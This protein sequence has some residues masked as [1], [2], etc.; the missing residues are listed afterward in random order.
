MRRSWPPSFYAIISEPL[1]GRER[2]A[3]LMVERRVPWIQLR[4]KHRPRAE[5][6]QAAKLL[7]EIIRPPSRFI[8]NDDPKLAAEV[9]ADGVHLGQDD[10]PYESAR[11]ILGPEAIIGLSTHNPEQVRAACEPGPDYIGVGP[12]FPTRTKEKPDP[13]LGLKGLRAALAVSTVPTVA[14]GGI[15]PRNARKVLEAGAAAIC[16]VG[17]INQQENPRFALDH[18]L[19]IIGE[20]AHNG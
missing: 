20:Y 14:I 18:L 2:L 15:D 3:A 16:A 5:V 6:R 10:M 19:R 12:V 7:R 9:G 8:L 1:V 13:L 17:C 11:Q 4:M